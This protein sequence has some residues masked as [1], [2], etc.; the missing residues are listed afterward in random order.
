[1]TT[2]RVELSVKCPYENEILVGIIGHVPGLGVDTTCINTTTWQLS[3]MFIK[4]H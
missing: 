3:L 1:M 2:I 4:C